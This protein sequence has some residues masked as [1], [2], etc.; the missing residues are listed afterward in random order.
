MNEINLL[1]FHNRLFHNLGQEYY[2]VNIY[3]CPITSCANYFLQSIK[4]NA[5]EN[6]EYAVKN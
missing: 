2:V 3:Q 1:R 4:M 6:Q 5:F